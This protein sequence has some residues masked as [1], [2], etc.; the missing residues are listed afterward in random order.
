MNKHIGAFVDVGAVTSASVP[1]MVRS[2]L[3]SW[4]VLFLPQAPRRWSHEMISMAGQRAQS[5]RLGFCE[6][7]VLRTSSDGMWCSLC[8]APAVFRFS[9]FQQS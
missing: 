7:L 3:G 1:V 6:S 5:T 4:G 2:V 9:G 8:P